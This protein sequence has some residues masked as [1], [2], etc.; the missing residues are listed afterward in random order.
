VTF[1]K[2][3]SLDDALKPEA[4]EAGLPKVRILWALAIALAALAAGQTWALVKFQPLGIDFLPLWTAGRMAWSDPGHLYDFAAVTHAQGWLLPNFRWM[5]P[6]AYPPT[7]LLVLAPFG[8]LPFW[9]ALALWT[10]LSFGVFLTAGARL[11][12]RSRGLAL[13]LMILSP[14]VVLAALAGQTVVLAA[15]LAALALADLER[16]PRLA[17]VLIALAAALKPQAALLAPVALLACGALETL[18]VAALAG[19]ALAAISVLCFGFARWPEWLASLGP[20]QAVV[21][22]IPHLMPG[23][24]TPYG[25][26]HEL[27]LAGAA[28]T[29][30]RAGFGLFGL[31][32]VWRVFAKTRDPA[33]RLAALGAGSLLAAPYAMHYDGALLAIPAVILALRLDRPGWLRRMLA[34]CAICEVTTP[35]LGLAAVT[36]F[37]VLACWELRPLGTRTRTSAA[38]A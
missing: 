5:R 38:A 27:G 16:R 37:A 18:A 9:P 12:K 4:P 23:V 33:T 15:G 30:W 6:Y 20:F 13:A 7:A 3:S 32:L 21:E 8:A 28:A 36:M 31:A 10:A 29:L 34:L 14:P 26:A 22:S 2:L 17:G 11:A 35:D 24:I 19:A 25:A 1:A